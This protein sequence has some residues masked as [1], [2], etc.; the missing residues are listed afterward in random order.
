MITR[1][2]FVRTG[3]E[4]PGRPRRGF[5][6]PRRTAPCARALRRN[7]RGSKRS[8]RNVGRLVHGNS[9]D[10]ASGRA[11]RSR[12]GG[13]PA[14]PCLTGLAGRAAAGLLL[15]LAVWRRSCRC[16]RRRRTRT[17]RGRRTSSSSWPDD[18]GYGDVGY[19]NSQSQIPTPNLDTLAGT[20]YGVSG[21]AFA[22]GGLHPDAL[23]PVDRPL[24]VADTTDPGESWT[25]TTGP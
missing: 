6:S 19:L 8:L 15:A 12:P 22:G 16:G 23:R 5:R 2:N 7:A 20:G 18:L 11:G 24:C 1:A 14:L 25:V 10:D 21:R 4:K 3:R 9:Q 17:L 13:S